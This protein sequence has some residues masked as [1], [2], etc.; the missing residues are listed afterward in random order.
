M[1]TTTRRRTRNKNRTFFFLVW[2]GEGQTSKGKNFRGCAVDMSNWT[3]TKW[4]VTVFFFFVIVKHLIHNRHQIR[5]TGVTKGHERITKKK[6]V[7][8][9]LYRVRHPKPTRRKK[10]NTFFVFPRKTQ[11]QIL[12][13]LGLNRFNLAQI[14]LL[15]MYPPY[16]P[17]ALSLIRLNWAPITIWHNRKCVHF[18]QKSLHPIGH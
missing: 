13:N 18:F 12:T 4:R 1:N 16:K 15:A 14:C 6:S 3:M 7:L 11:T 2:C 9:F 5:E 8:C 17:R 10:K